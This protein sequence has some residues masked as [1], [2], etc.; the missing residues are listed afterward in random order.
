MANAKAS[1]DHRHCAVFFAHFVQARTATWDDHVD[2]IIHFQELRHQFTIWLFNVLHGSR[3]QTCFIQRRL[4]HFDQ[5]HVRE[6]RLFA[7]AQNRGVTG[8]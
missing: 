6:K 1:N 5:F 3:W 4:D 2:V 8:F 7:T